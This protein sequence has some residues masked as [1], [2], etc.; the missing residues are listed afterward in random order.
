M[1]RV[2]EP[3]KTLTEVID[4]VERIREE[5]LNL[6]RSLEEIEVAETESAEAV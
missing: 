6:Q 2:A 3:R 1:T 4:E 5:L